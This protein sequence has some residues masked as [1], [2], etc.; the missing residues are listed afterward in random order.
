MQKFYYQLFL[1]VGT[2]V[3]FLNFELKNLREYYNKIQIASRHVKK[4]TRRSCQM[5]KRSLIGLSLL[6]SFLGDFKIFVLPKKF[7][8]Y[9]RLHITY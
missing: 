3:Y 2:V 6:S 1:T 7:R 9:G 4:E 8:L 5:K